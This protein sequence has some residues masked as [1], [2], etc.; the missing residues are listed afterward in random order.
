MLNKMLGPDGTDAALR[1]APGTHAHLRYDYGAAS[2][3]FG[4]G[5]GG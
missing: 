1:S 3:A 5:T 4:F 2:S